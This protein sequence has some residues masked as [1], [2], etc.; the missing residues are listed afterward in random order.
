MV[1]PFKHVSSLTKLAKAELDDVFETV[2]LTENVLNEVYKCDGLNI[3]INVGKAAG[4]GVDEHIHIHLVPRWL[5]DCNFMSVVGEKRVIPEA[6]ELTYKKLK[7]AFVR[8]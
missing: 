1:V 3:G 6:F 5:G 4:A 8:S 2:Q 7:T